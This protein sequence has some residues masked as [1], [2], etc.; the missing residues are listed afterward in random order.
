M[1]Y[2][3][4][5]SRLKPPASSCWGGGGE[6]E[7]DGDYDDD[8][9]GGQGEDV[10]DG[11]RREE[12]HSNAELDLELCIEDIGWKER[13]QGCIDKIFAYALDHYKDT[14]IFDQVVT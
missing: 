2:G 8:G 14:P 6:E 12:F 7:S 5:Y 10:D 4:T 11:L 13:G 1:G 3:R 9:D